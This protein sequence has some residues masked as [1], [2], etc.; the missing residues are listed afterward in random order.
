[1]LPNEAWGKPRDAARLPEPRGNGFWTQEIYY[2]ILNAGLRLPPSAGSAS[3]VLPNPVGYNRI[4]VHLGDTLDYKSWWEGIKAGRSFVSNGPLLRCRANGQW[5]GHVFSCGEGETL[6]IDVEASL[7]SLDPVSEI[8]IIRNGAIERTVPA[9]S[10]EKNLKLGPIEFRESG[11]FLV[12]VVAN[13]AKT[14]RFASTA[15]FYVEVGAGK[16][17]ISK[18]SAQFFLDWAHE[19]KNRVKLADDSQLAEV[20]AHHDTAERFWTERVSRANAE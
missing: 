1:M 19:R 15:P 18:R 10:F 8:E 14:F 11:W 13:E 9:S 16:H 2:H 3:G 6:K 4:Y 12:R 20:L 5:P 7:T 17:R